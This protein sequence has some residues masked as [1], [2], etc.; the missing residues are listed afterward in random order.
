MMRLNI[1]NFGRD[2]NIRFI[3]RQATGHLKV[4]FEELLRDL[5]NNRGNHGLSAVFEHMLL[6]I[7]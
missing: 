4:A 6:F 7:L 1:V 3:K 2:V 5:L